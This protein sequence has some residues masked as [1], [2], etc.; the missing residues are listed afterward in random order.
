MYMGDGV[1]MLPSQDMYRNTSKSKIYEA[2]KKKFGESIR[3][4]RR[5]ANLSQESVALRINADQA[6]ISRIEAGLF[7]P[8]L[9]TIAELAKALDLPI[10]KLFDE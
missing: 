4:H 5:A 6:Y 1:V 9:E 7:N 10:R 2:A 3:K 8:T